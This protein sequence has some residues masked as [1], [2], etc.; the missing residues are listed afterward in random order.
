[1]KKIFISL[2]A[3]FITASFVIGQENSENLSK[4]IGDGDKRSTTTI[5]KGDNIKLKTFFIE[6]SSA[7]QN[8]AILPR[9]VELN[10]QGIRLTQKKDYQNALELFEQADHLA[11]RN[12]QILFNLGTAFLNLKRDVEAVEVFAKIIEI[13]PKNANAFGSLG[14]ALNNLS[15]T[16]ESF[17]AFRRALEIYPEDTVTLCNYANALHHA[18]NEVEALAI[19]QQ[20]IKLPA[21]NFSAAYNIR[22]TI[23]FNLKKYAE[24]KNDFELAARLDPKSADPVNNL[25]VVFSREGK[26]KKALKYFLEAEVLAPDWD[27]VAYNL[28]L[29]FSETGNREKSNE[30]LLKLGNSNPAIAEQ[31]KKALQQKYI[32]DV[33][34]IK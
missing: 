26:K 13:A 30:Y 20:A 21:G 32:L 3:I 25:G 16:K 10:N 33:S 12:E 14:L 7:A 15:K 34:K 28:A 6:N 22:G 29:N 8:S 18:G 19:V 27:D 17:S 31:L 4:Q 5:Y 23:F 1:M 24:A 2:T 11:P 9:A